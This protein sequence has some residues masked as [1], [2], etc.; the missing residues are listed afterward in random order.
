MS[1]C[2]PPTDRGETSNTSSGDEHL[3]GRDLSGGRHLP[4]EESTEFVRRLNDRTVSGDVR[5]RDTNDAVRRNHQR[6]RRGLH[7]G[8][9]REQHRHG[10]VAVTVQDER[11]HRDVAQVV[12]EVLDAEERLQEIPELAPEIGPD[13]LSLFS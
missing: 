10:R 1:P 3:R 12:T 2:P 7:L 5:H 8:R 4:G 11:G 6:K 13:P 9:T